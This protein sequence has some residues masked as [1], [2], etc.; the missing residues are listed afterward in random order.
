LA[1]R[2]ISGGR[3]PTGWQDSSVVLPMP[4]FETI[5]VHRI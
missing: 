3:A 5:S 4:R 1:D 2:Q